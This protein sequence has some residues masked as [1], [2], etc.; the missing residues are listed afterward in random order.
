MLDLT[1][2][3]E[4]MAQR[5][6]GDSRSEFVRRLVLER[7]PEA[8]EKEIAAAFPDDAPDASA[9]V[10]A[11]IADAVTDA[12]EALEARLSELERGLPWRVH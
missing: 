9:G 4:A 12:I 7:C 6:R 5:Q 2:E 11:E 1:T 3:G 8:T 10:L